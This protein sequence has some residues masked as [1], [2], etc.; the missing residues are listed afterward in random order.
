M[1]FTLGMNAVLQGLVVLYTGGSAPASHATKL[2]S[3]MAVGRTFGIPYSCSC[4]EPCRCS[5]L[6]Y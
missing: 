5:L 6:F 2:M 4:G 3:V 1:I